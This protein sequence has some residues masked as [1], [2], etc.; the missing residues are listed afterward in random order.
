[1]I[2]VCIGMIRSGSTL[3][4]NMARGLVERTLS[5]AGEGFYTSKEIGVQRQKM[6]DW[7][8]DK[9]SHVVKTHELHPLLREMEL[10]KS[11]SFLYIY[12]D[13]RDVAVSVKHKFGHKG[14]ELIKAIDKALKT[15][16]E[17]SAVKT[18]LWQRY[19]SVIGNVP[20]AVME[21]AKFIGVPAGGEVIE[22]VSQE[23]SLESAVQVSGVFAK[24]MS[25]RV[26]RILRRLRP[27][28]GAYDKR[29]LL[30]ADHIS[31]NLGGIGVWRKELSAQEK[32]MIISRYGLWLEKRGY[33]S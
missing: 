7:A 17:M 18:V 15:F 16:E 11:A 4:Y 30:H 28:L 22:D 32:E 26:G 9:S 23:C 12:R 8:A 19:E 6:A 14:D 31:K 1:M 33:L 20:A 2:M 29:T 25:G 13:I 21:L 5:G 24:S 27:S 10:E 3:Q